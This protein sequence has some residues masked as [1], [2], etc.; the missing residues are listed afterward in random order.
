MY[1]IVITFLLIILT[2]GCSPDLSDDPIP[3]QPFPEILIDLNLPAYI[4]LKTDGGH[5][6]LNDGGV[7]GII[8]YRQNSLTYF[9][10]ERNCSFHPADA[11]ATVDVDVSNLYMIDPCC[12][13]TFSFSTGEPTGGIAWRPLRKYATS[14]DTNLLTI[15]DEIIQ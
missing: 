10:Y 4:K 7:R 8:L 13:S 1:R 14:L 12:S 2:T 15:T 3:F 11:C 6:Y 9:A 5:M